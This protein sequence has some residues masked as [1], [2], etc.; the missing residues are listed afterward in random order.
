MFDA[1]TVNLIGLLISGAGLAAIFPTMVAHTPR[2]VGLH[3]APNTV[4]FL[5]S[6]ASAGTAAVAG[7]GAVLAGQMGFGV[8]APY[9]TLSMAVTL[10][11][12]LVIAARGAARAGKI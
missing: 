7:L 1:P 9:L 11:L 5:I 12:Y 2:R 4:G 3:H 6:T 8:I 10:G